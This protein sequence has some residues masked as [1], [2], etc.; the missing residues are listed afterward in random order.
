MKLSEL[1][2]KIRLLGYRHEKLCKKHYNFEPLKHV[3][4]FIDYRKSSELYGLAFELLHYTKH[5]LFRC[6]LP[7]KSEL[8]PDRIQDT[9]P[10]SLFSG[11]EFCLEVAARRFTSSQVIFINELSLLISRIRFLIG[12]AK[13]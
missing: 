12:E 6:R 9:S 13:P 3:R 2:N 1:L 10:P 11:D 8:S 4:V 7:A 5:G